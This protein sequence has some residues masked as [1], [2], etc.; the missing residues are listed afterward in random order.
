MRTTSASDPADPKALLD[1]VNS[2]SEKVAALHIAF[3][4]LCTYVLVIVFSTTDLD[5]LLGKGIKLPVVDVEVPIVG[6]Y[7]TVPYLLVLVHF[8]LLLVLQLHSRKLH[9]LDETILGRVGVVDRTDKFYADKYHRLETSNH[10]IGLYDRLNLFPFNYY[11]VGRPSR[12]VAFFVASLV[13]ITILLLPVVSLLTLQARFL[14]Y[15]SVSVTWAQRLAVWLDTGLVAILWPIIIDRHDNWR[16]FGNRVWQS[17]KERP[18][19]WAWG[20]AGLAV[21]VSIFIRDWDWEIS[22]WLAIT[23]AIWLLL[24]MSRPAWRRVL[25]WLSRGR[26]FGD[27]QM[28]PAVFGLGGLL[29]VILFGL[30]LPLL[31]LVDGESI[32]QPGWPTTKMLRPMRQLDLA[33]KILLA[34]PA[35]PATIIDLRGPD[36]TRRDAA[37]RSIERIDLRNRSLR[38][39]YLSKALLPL[40]DLRVAHLQ[41]VNLARA[42]LQFADL[43]HAHLQGADL[44]GAQLR[45]AN[46]LGAQLHGANLTGAKLQGAV[47]MFAQLQGAN[48][49]GAQLQ[50]ADLMNAQLH[51]ANL[52]V[53][54]LQG[55]DLRGAQLNGA[56]LRFAS[57][58]TKYMPKSIELVDVRGLKWEPPTAKEV[59]AMQ[60]EGLRWDQTHSNAVPPQI[61][62]C[63]RDNSTRVTCK[64][65]HDLQQFSELIYAELWGLACV[66]PYI[67]QE[68]LHNALQGQSLPA[69]RRGGEIYQ[70]FAIRLYDSHKQ[71]MGESSCPGLLFSNDRGKVLL[72]RMSRWLE[73]SQR[74]GEPILRENFDAGRNR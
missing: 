23:L 35:L 39:A 24:T 29:A 2:A 30:P 74:P 41:G 25:R 63:L 57:L 6:F 4:A 66:S 67:A 14:G 56:S 51:G 22:T 38:N 17:I 9:A 10:D 37:L 40:A 16:A 13:I 18:W 3:L 69:A 32:D 34:K 15:Q 48:L 60:Q 21:A 19:R 44:S 47:L 12:V 53:A 61:K 8:H 27:S 50:G 68:V 36:P 72:K 5:L 49:V 7:A 70:Y 33:E 11:L 55:T 28:K 45:G 42:E 26:Y 64:D 58:Y 73:E 71:G 54:K 65:S 59:L 52:S 46:L 20:F 43:A 31:L 1:A 62:S